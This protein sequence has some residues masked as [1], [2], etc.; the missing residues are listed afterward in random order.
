MF[1]RKKSP[2]PPRFC[3]ALCLFLSLSLS[4]SLFLDASPSSNGESALSS[5]FPDWISAC[6]FVCVC[7][8]NWDYKRGV[9]SRQL[10]RAQTRTRAQRDTR[11][12]QEWPGMG[13]IK[14]EKELASNGNA[15][16]NELALFCSKTAASARESMLA[17]APEKGP[18]LQCTHSRVHLRRIYIIYRYTYV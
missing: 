17:A 16:L 8:Q 10:S 7:E 6:V 3:S 11:R 18:A 15:P 2:I 14:R 12:C 4:L 5:S 9:E 13:W 1:S